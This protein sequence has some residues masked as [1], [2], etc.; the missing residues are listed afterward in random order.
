MEGESQ[1]SWW[2]SACNYE[3]TC[4]NNYWALIP[5]GGDEVSLSTY[6]VLIYTTPDYWVYQLFTFD[7]DASYY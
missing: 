4:T 1:W 3:L 7:L 2:A 5:Y 6:K